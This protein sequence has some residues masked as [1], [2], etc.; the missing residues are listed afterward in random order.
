MMIQA[1]KKGCRLIDVCI[2]DPEFQ[3]VF[4]T[5]SEE[6]Q[7]IL[8]GNIEQY[9]GFTRARTDENLARVR[10]LTLPSQK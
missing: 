4:A 3:A 7:T 10:A 8:S 6:H 5:L 9:I 1:N 2:E